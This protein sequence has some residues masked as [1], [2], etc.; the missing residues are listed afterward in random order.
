MISDSKA[1]VKIL[2]I[3][4]TEDGE[5]KLGEACIRIPFETLLIHLLLFGR[6]SHS[7]L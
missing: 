3:D 7:I 5:F 1:E 6:N 4:T 2:L